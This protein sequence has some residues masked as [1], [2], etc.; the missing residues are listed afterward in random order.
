MI[1]FTNAATSEILKKREILSS[2]DVLLSNETDKEDFWSMVLDFDPAP[3]FLLNTFSNSVHHP[4]KQ[5]SNIWNRM[6]SLTPPTSDEVKERGLV[7]VDV[8]AKLGHF[9][10][11]A[12]SMGYKVIAFEPLSRNTYKMAKSKSVNRGLDITLYQNAIS[13]VSGEIVQLPTNGIDYVTSLTLTDAMEGGM[14]AYIVKIDA[15]D[16]ENILNGALDW[17]CHQTVQYIIMAISESSRTT[18]SLPALLHFMQSAGYEISDVDLTSDHSNVDHYNFYDVE[19][20]EFLPPHILFSLH[21]M[22]KHATC[23]HNE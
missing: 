12:A 4:T 10:L 3:N 22:E 18:T 8:G 5:D 15:E 2:N 13:D 6:V 17:V 14:N 16:N 9:S 1:S 23:P 19:V 7:F 21:E 20:L 11:A